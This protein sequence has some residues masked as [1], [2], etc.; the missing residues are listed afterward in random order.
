[1][2]LKVQS[3][4]DE[5]PHHHSKI[6]TQ[7]AGHGGVHDNAG[8][9][10]KVKTLTS[11][12]VGCHSMVPEDPASG[13]G[14]SV[15]IHWNGERER[16]SL[17]SHKEHHEKSYQQMDRWGLY[18]SRQ[19]PRGQSHSAW[20]QGSASWAYNCQMALPDILPAAYWRSS[21]VFQN[22]YLHDMASIADG[23]STLGPVVVAQQVVDPGHLLP[24]P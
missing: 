4:L 12:V 2:H 16:L 1:M 24:P 22:S 7:V 15:F 6:S 10:S 19:R 23:M 5:Q 13:G 21:R 20:S 17:S 8:T 9:S 14:G 3:A 11:P 18:M